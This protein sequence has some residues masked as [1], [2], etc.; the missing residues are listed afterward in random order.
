VLIENFLEP[1]KYKQVPHAGKAKR[2]KKST[3]PLHWI[4]TQMVLTFSKKK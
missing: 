3:G 1:D 4:K 2:P